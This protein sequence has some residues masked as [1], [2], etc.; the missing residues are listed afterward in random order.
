MW[1]W[2]V[3]WYEIGVSPN[4]APMERA[5][6][7]SAWIRFINEGTCKYL[8]KL[9][10]EYRHLWDIADLLQMKVRT[11]DVRWRLKPSLR[12]THTLVLC[13]FAWDVL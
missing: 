12:Y 4:C 13:V 5:V 2:G 8:S 3:S 11:V 1:M 7:N 6:E 10:G 9:S